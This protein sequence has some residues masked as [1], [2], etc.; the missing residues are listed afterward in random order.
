MAALMVAEHPE[1]EAP[2]YHT[3]TLLSDPLDPVRNRSPSQSPGVVELLVSVMGE[4]E[5]PALMSRKPCPSTVMSPWLS[6]VK[7]NV[8]PDCT[9]RVPACAAVPCMSNAP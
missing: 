8:T 9:T 1:Y 2:A 5:V 7:V 6:E 4:P 3:L